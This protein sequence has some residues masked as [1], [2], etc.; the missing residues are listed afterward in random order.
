MGARDV[1]QYDMTWT[2]YGSSGRMLYTLY[3]MCYSAHGMLVFRSQVDA[4]ML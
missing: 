1:V 3:E 2:S 4:K